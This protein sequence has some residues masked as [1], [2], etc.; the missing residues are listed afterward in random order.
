MFFDIAIIGSGN[1]SYHLAYRLKQL[2]NPPKMIYG[3]SKSDLMQL[4]KD[5]NLPPNISDLKNV[6]DVDFAIIAA[7]DD[8]IEEVAKT[9][10]FQQHT[11]VLHVSG[12]KSINVLSAHKQFGV[13]YPLQT[14]S[15]EKEIDFEGVPILI[16]GNNDDA[17]RKIEKLAHF[18]SNNVKQVNTADRM[19]IHLAA[20]FACN[21]A[22]LMYHQAEL[23]LRETQ[24]TLSDMKYL[25]K[26]TNEKAL[27]IGALK[28]QTGP[29]IRSDLGILDQ[30]LSILATDDEKKEMYELLSKAILKMRK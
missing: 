1:V 3:R 25:L 6:D 9:Y 10:T 30:H 15:R 29:A 4:T 21:F 12:S 24:V 8:A 27:Q 11:I 17:T 18:L 14:F 16:E 2:G 13:M 22:N 7:S 19:K 26:E 5:L 23:L 28:A 20:V